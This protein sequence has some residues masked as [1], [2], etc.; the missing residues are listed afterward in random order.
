MLLRME[1]TDDT[2]I[3][4]ETVEVQSVG[5]FPQILVKL[6]HPSL[7]S[8]NKVQFWAKWVEMSP[9]WPQR[10]W[11]EWGGGGQR[12]EP[13]ANQ[14]IVIRS[15]MSPTQQYYLE[16]FFFFTQSQVLLTSIL[17]TS[18]FSVNHSP[19]WVIVAKFPLES[20]F[21]LQKITILLFL[22]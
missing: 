18:L 17:V 15:L 12:D 7:P 22:R 20:L 8:L 13:K 11:E 3:L 1:V 14:K 6:A 21:L 4:Y 16:E 10:C 5:T 9:F 2:N 19:P